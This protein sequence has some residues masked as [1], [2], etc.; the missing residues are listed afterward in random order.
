MRMEMDEDENQV[1]ILIMVMLLMMMMILH[2]IMMILLLIMVMKIWHHTSPKIPLK[3][4]ESKYL[5]LAS[6]TS[7]KPPNKK[8][9]DAKY[10]GIF[11]GLF[12]ASYTSPKITLKTENKYLHQ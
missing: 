6:K 11:G 3:T 1:M 4:G 7:S 5:F 12:L 9:L 10:Y 2:L 8:L